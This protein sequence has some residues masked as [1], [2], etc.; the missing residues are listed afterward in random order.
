VEEGAGGD[1]RDS[2]E[3]RNEALRRR[4]AAPSP[5]GAAA[6]RLG[7]G[8]AAPRQARRL[9]AGRRGAGSCR[10]CMRRR[11]GGWWR[12]ADSW[13]R[14]RLRTRRAPR[15]RAHTRTRARRRALTGARGQVFREREIGRLREQRVFDPAKRRWFEWAVPRDADGN[16]PQGRDSG[17][18]TPASA[19]SFT[20]GP[21]S[22]LAA[23][24]SGRNLS[25]VAG[26]AAP[27]A[28]PPP[29]PAGFR[30]AWALGVG[31]VDD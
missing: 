21:A 31:G 1:V 8:R 12:C 11:T 27:P 4:R 2:A 23:G 9:N 20:R 14:S 24:L 10:R 28:P 7:E 29:P 15:A 18:S 5:A 25:W 26:A 6:Q 3:Q 22:W 13:K 30:P 17:L 16:L 19:S